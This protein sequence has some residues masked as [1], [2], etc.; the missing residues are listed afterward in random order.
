MRK[1]ENVIGNRYGRLVVIG[2]AEPYIWR[3]K[4]NR[5][6][7]CLCDCGNIVFCRLS[8]LKCGLTK[9]CGCYGREVTSKITAKTNSYDFYDDYVVG[10]CSNCDDVFYVDLE[11]YEKIKNYCW[12][13]HKTNGYI[14][15]NAYKS[16][17]QKKE[18][19]L[20]RL[21]MNAKEGDIVD[22][23]NGQKT[24]NRKSNLRFCNVYQNGMNSTNKTKKVSKET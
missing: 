9:S 1:R 13:K 4:K 3:G 15:S 5:M 18:I 14:I 22:H 17:G 12:L 20:H 23:I 16:N 21:I 2:D 10:H 24:D 19:K 8:A 7:K 6:E 11:D